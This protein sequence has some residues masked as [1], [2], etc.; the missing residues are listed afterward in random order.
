MLKAHYTRVCEVVS[1]ENG[2]CVPPYPYI[3]S[4]RE[5]CHTLFMV[6]GGCGVILSER[7]GS[8]G[9]SPH[10]GAYNG[11]DGDFTSPIL[12]RSEGRLRRCCDYGG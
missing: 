7:Q 4:K 3:R 8:A 6:C 2:V 5:Y 11:G 12:S 10:G 1:G 9:G